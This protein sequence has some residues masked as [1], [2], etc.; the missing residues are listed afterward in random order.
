MDFEI[1]ARPLTFHS[2]IITPVLTPVKVGPEPQPETALNGT[3][4]FPKR[5]FC[6]HFSVQLAI[7]PI[8]SDGFESRWGYH[9][10]PRFGGVF[11]LPKSGVHPEELLRDATEEGGRPAKSTSPPHPVR[12]DAGPDSKYDPARGLTEDRN[13][14]RRPHPVVGQPTMRRRARSDP[15]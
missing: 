3:A 2:V 4:S 5:W 8:L 11:S 6:P 10:K 15:G 14:I 9:L 1:A 7:I 12:L 13:H